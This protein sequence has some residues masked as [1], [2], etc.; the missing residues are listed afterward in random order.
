MSKLQKEYAHSANFKRS[1]F[2]EL[3]KRHSAIKSSARFF[4]IAE[5]QKLACNI[6]HIA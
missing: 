1:L 4:S 5:A 3:A 6:H 2:N